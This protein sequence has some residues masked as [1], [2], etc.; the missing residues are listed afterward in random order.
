MY[1][2][3]STKN[4]KLNNDLKKYLKGINYKYYVD[5]KKKERVI[6]FFNSYNFIWQHFIDFVK[7]KRKWTYEDL[8]VNDYFY[9][10]YK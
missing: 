2:T 10:S 3:Y 1:L 7:I 9:I 5:Y 8:L 4:K 6:L